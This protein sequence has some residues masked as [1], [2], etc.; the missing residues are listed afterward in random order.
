[1]SKVPKKPKYR[2]KKTEVDGIT[3]DSKKEANRYGQLKLL[4]R[5]GK[6]GELKMQERFELFPAQRIDGKVV[7]RPWVYVADF[8]YIDE[9]GRRIVEDAKGVRTKD[10]IGKRKA[11]LAI[12]NIRIKEI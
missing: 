7:E 5:A 3:F 8:V 9:A 12:H 1:M 6:I 2:N 4:Q 11:M 10:Y